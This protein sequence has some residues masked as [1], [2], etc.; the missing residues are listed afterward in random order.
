VRWVSTRNKVA[1]WIP[2]AADP[3]VR[4]FH[5][6]YKQLDRVLLRLPYRKSR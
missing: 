1:T 6:T 4:A 2:L 5:A 3:L